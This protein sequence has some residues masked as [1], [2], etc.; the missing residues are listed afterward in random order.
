[1]NNLISGAGIVGPTIAY[2]LLQYG[3]NSTSAEQAP[4]LRTGGYVNDF[5][6]GGFD[7][8][9]RMGLSEQIENNG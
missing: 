9:E 7:I 6:G 8:A 2:W 3:I 4:A 5:W 1:M